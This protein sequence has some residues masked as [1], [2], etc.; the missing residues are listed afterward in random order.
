MSA[1]HRIAATAIAAGATTLGLAVAPAAQ[2]L[3]SPHPSFIGRFHAISTLAS[4]VPANGDVNPYGTVVV[5]RGYG[6]LRA[7]DVLISNF[8]NKANEQGTGTTLVQVSPAGRRTLFARVHGA[9]PGA[10]PGGIGLSTALAVLQDGWVVVGSVPSA[11]GSAATSKAG[12]LVV[13]DSQGRV[14]ETISGHGINGP[15]DATAVTA[16][17]QADLFVTNVLNG[18]VA[19]KGGVVHRG[20]VLRLR[21]RVAGRRLPRLESVT[22]IGSGFAEQS[23]AAA[24]VLGPTGV[25]LGRHDTLYVADTRGNR[26][27]AIPAALTRQASAGTGRILTRGGALS[28]PLGLAIAPGGDVLTVNADNGAIVETTPAGTQ[29]ATR[30]LDRSGRPRGAGALFGLAVAPAGRGLYYVDDAVNTLRLLHN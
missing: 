11:D 2:A 3:A 19:A 25:G 28:A 23:S 16:G 30:L 8:N 22:K 27:T 7:G 12:C 1:V 6:R 29:L 13:L 21:L 4:T 18:T 5:R 26:V 17:D 24:F 10:C 9:L 14:R 15:W 20:T